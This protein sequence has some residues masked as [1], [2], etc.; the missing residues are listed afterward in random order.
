MRAV[1]GLQ[2]LPPA[3]V[4]KLYRLFGHLQGG[5]LVFPDKSSTGV[6]FSSA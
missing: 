5:G 3:D 6:P 2:A 4:E 1:S